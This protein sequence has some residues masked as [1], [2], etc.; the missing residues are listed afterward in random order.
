MNKIYSFFACA[1]LAAST[2]SAQVTVIYSQT[3]DNTVN[4]TLINIP[5]WNW[6]VSD[7]G[8]SEGTARQ[9][10]RL[11]NGTGIGAIQEGSLGVAHPPPSGMG[12]PPLSPRAGGPLSPKGLRTPLARFYWSQHSSQRPSRPRCFPPSLLPLSPREE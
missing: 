1:A 11:S 2:A 3:F 5:G 7:G 9:F 4:A 8:D 10:S 6:A 12:P